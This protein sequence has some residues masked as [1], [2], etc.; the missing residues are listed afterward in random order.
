MIYKLV[1][2]LTEKNITDKELV[3]SVATKGQAMQVND[4]LKASGNVVKAEMS[5]VVEL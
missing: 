1:V 2:E 5:K 3:V 4:S